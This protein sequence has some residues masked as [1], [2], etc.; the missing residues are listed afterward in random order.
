LRTGKGD[1]PSCTTYTNRWELATFF[2]TC[3]ILLLM[4]LVCIH[5]PTRKSSPSSPLCRNL[6]STQKADWGK[7][8][9]A[10]KDTAEEDAKVERLREKV[11][12]LEKELQ[13]VKSTK[14]RPPS[15]RS[16]RGDAGAEKGKER[17]YADSVRL[18][19]TEQ[20]LHSFV[21]CI[22]ISSAAHQNQKTQRT[23]ETK[24]DL[25]FSCTSF[26]R[27]QHAHHARKEG[28]LQLQARPETI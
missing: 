2:M 9:A 14:I 1:S 20:S 3:M 8:Q 16:H 15:A 23:E 18:P 6:T 5:R 25:Q 4:M 21:F 24:N 22:I 28:F 10:S 26:H 11:E 17:D 27:A 7:T 12:G 19:P 13:G